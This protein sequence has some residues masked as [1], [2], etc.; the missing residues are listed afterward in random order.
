MLNYIWLGLV[1]LA[2]IIGGCTDNLK[3]IA[4]K[5][6]EMAE[7]A[8]MRTALPLVGIMA[9]WLGIMRLAERA[10]LVAALA[11]L[12]R[13]LMVWLFPEVP[14]DHPA[15]GAMLLNMAASILGLGNAATPL[16][17]KAMRHLETLNPRPGTATNAMCT[18]L[19]I[20]TSSIQLIPATA[21]A[22]LAAN[23]SSNPTAIVGTSIIATTCAAVAAVTAAKILQ[24]LPFYRLPPAPA[25]PAESAPEPAAPAPA[26]AG[27]EKTPIREAA[28]LAPLR[29]WGMLIMSAFGLFFLYVFLRLAFPAVVGL[30]P[31]SDAAGQTVFIRIVDA[32]SRIS[33]PFMLSVFPLYA[34][35]R[36]VK[37][38]E[39]FVDGAKEGFDVALRIIPYLV[40]ILVAM[41]MFRAAGGIDL[42]SRALAPVMEA[43]GFP[44]PLLPMVLMRPLSGSGTLG[45]LAELVK[46]YGP[47]SLISRTGGTIF[48]STE[49]TFYVLA[50]YFGSVGV[51]RTRYA[52][53]A[54]I[55]A[56]TVGV[57][58]SVI[59]CR[60][61]FG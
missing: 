47:D 37:V 36:R 2:V 17:L 9:L 10:G 28:D 13:P 8:V 54:G 40:A 58:A 29:W 59:V 42:I 25:P 49:T 50:V 7:F 57:I 14:H 27:N 18:Y 34:A 19:A 38:Y 26:S 23:K 51:K 35:L 20:N 22:I 12:L 21:I 32:I 55:V 4:D 60:L 30:T 53:P 16:G 46:Q 45:L 39:E 44:S 52:L 61:V 5:S 33:I 48:G 24:R 3:A 1:V 11:R 15:M 41:G 31:P 6:F 56:D 43:V